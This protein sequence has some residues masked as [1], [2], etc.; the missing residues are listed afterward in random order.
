MCGFAGFL[1]PRGKTDPSQ[2]PAQLTAM[3]G[4]I[5]PRGP[6]HAG[7][8]SDPHA[9]VALGF[10]RLSILDLSPAGHQPMASANGRFQLVYNGEIYNAQEMKADLERTG[11][12]GWR[13]HS[14]T[15]VLL[16]AIGRWGAAATLP[17]LDGMFAFA[18]WDRETRT[19]TLARDRFGEKPLCYGWQK[20]VFLFGSTLAALRPHPSWTSRVSA[21]AVSAYLARSYVP[22]PLTIQEGM[23]KLPPGYWASIQPGTSDAL[24]MHCYFDPL[25]EAEQQRGTSESHST[26]ESIETL[27]ELI[28]RSVERRLHADV[29]VG[30]FLS[31]GIDSSTVVAH[32]AKATSNRIKT[33]TIAFPDS[34]YD[35]APFAREV[36]SH[37]G[38][39]HHEMPVT[40][41]DARNLLPDLPT[42]YDE[43]FADPSAL[44][45]MIL[46][47]KTRAHVTVALSGD[48]GDEFFGGYGRYR[49]AASDWSAAKARPAWMRSIARYLSGVPGMP[50]RKKLARGG[51]ERIDAAY[52]PYVTRWRWDMPGKAPTNTPWPPTCL[53]PQAR[54]MVEDTRTYLPDDLQV[55]MDRASM[56]AS[57]EVRAP[58][59]DHAIA[60][61]AWA[62]PLSH[63]IHPQLGGKYLLRRVLARHVPERLFERPKMGFYQPL[64]D[65]L[66]GELRE[67]AENLLSEKALAQ[68][69]LLDVTRVRAA[70]AAHLRGR[71]RA[72]DLWTILMLQQ[73][74]AAHGS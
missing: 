22:A 20:G 55:K 56:S 62:Q 74:L 21:K 69:G 52:L 32:A 36:A 39:D 24:Q 61:F 72:L 47:R 71:N 29:P 34:D 3:T 43:P 68:S 28:A 6:D 35:E 38:T 41:L 45:S 63:R 31:G 15:E 14:D 26:E 70:W 33:F 67:W 25:A 64:P 8:W 53:D 57:L 66:R 16:E 7:Q 23:A 12:V 27:D 9:G 40:D 65:W 18:L 44:P 48:G 11:P 49:D 17:K 30:I 10:R 73:W 60:R 2:W 51:M 54:F 58:L 42:T 5:A 19:L 4:A 13:G 46:S 59:L 37:L 50:T 1:D